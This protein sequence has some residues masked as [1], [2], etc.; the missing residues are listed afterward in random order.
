MGVSKV[1][2]NKK[3]LVDLT[4]STVTEDTLIKGTTAFNS[5]GEKI[6]GSA[7][8]INCY[9][10]NDTEQISLAS[11]TLANS[12]VNFYFDIGTENK[13]IGALTFNAGRS[14]EQY[15]EESYTNGILT[16]ISMIGITAVRDYQFYNCSKVATITLPTGLASVGGNAFNGC[17]S[18]KAVQF[19]AEVETVDTK[20][21]ANCTSLQTAR[22]NGTPTSIASDVFTG[23]TKLTMIIV[24][25][26]ED[27]VPGAPWGA[28]NATVQYLA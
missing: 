8:K 19:P 17:S 7:E 20:A 10:E 22:F 24:P 15:V 28:T 6:T 27:S 25:W 1:V 9:L 13:E 23:C 21:F 2:Y 3:T 26:T 14:S 12:D 11:M 5:K 4:D 18:L 16:G